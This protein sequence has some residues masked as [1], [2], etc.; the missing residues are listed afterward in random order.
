MTG[1][2]AITARYMRENSFT[3][4]PQFKLLLVGNHAP[5]ITNLDTAIQRRFLILPFHRKPAEI[6]LRLEEVLAAEMPGILRWAI[7][8]AV[9]WYTHG[10]IVPKVVSEATTQYFDEQDVLGQFLAERCDFDPQNPH[11]IEK[12]ADV[13]SQWSAFAKQ[14]AVEP[15][16][17]STFNASL[18]TRLGIAAPKQIKALSTKGFRGLR[19][20]LPAEDRYR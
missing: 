16:T 8:G 11:L 6:D 5:T 14:Q 2:D 17:Q 20:K 15:G 10:L 7:N 12:S 1:G 9:D 4:T 3:F 19:L 13:F 18:Q